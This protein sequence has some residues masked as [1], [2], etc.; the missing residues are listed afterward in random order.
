MA[1]V[2][3]VL[4]H[5]GITGFSGGFIGVDVFFVISGFLITSIIAREISENRFSLVSFYERRARRIL[6]ALAGVLL[7]CLVMGWFLLLPAELKGLGRSALATSLFASNIHFAMS[8]NYFANASEFEP[9]LHTWSLAVEEQFYLFFPPLLMALAMMGKSKH[10]F[11]LVLALSVLSL[12]AA[13]LL[14]DRS[15]Q[16]VF[17]LIIFRAWELGAGALLALWAVPA[18]RLRW[19]REI[20]GI[21]GLLAILIPVTVYTASTPFPG[22]AA[23]PPV[24]GAAILIWLGK[25]DNSAHTA[26]SYINTMLGNRLLVGI[27]LISYSLYLWHWPILAYLRIILGST[28]LPASYA[29]LA[30]IASLVMAWLS[31]R[32]VE[33][34]FRSQPPKGFTRGTV[35]AASAAMLSVPAVAGATFMITNGYA[36]RL[37]AQAAA[38]AAFASD[39]NPRRNECLGINPSQGLCEFGASSDGTAKAGFLLW[40]DS[41]ADMM[42][43][44]I[45]LAAKA[46]GQRGYFA[47]SAGCPPLLDVKRDN[48]FRACPQ[49]GADIWSWLEQRKDIDLVILAARWTLSVEG[50]RYGGEAGADITL[51]WIGAPDRR[52][53][54]AG[55]P[56]LFEAALQE[57]VERILA[58]GKRVVLI[59]P[60]PE[61]GYSVPNESARRAWLGLVPRANVTT[62]EYRQRAQRTENIL[63][64]VAQSSD[65]VQYIP[66]SDLFC[67]ATS[68]RSTGQ[69]GK[70]LYVDDDHL[71]RTTSESLLS[72]R[73]Q[74]IWNQSALPV[75]IVN[76][77]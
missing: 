55:N 27:G 38:I 33:Q 8:L 69:D 36:A 4:F 45:D 6:P 5:A 40:G 10:A 49:L 21:A 9:L 47:G 12:I 71:T 30:V 62:T 16:W 7:A 60:V 22:A 25:T 64:R 75:R 50:T 28:L 34:P 67:D 65:Q 35:F 43:P 73:F 41:H 18:P 13:I 39:R 77:P 32:F 61:V 17:Y 31:Y 51:E 74:I 63:M 70:P 19:L 56:A 42:M 76:A 20:L 66:M 68:C 57:V 53:S 14:L 54:S 46:A 26:G 1:V 23:V 2:P 44:G 11:R 29:A 59:G 48:E 24:A 52:P 3:V 58:K 37:P 72:P 15:P